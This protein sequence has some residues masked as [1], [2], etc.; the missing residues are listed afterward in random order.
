MQQIKESIIN[1]H[2]QMPKCVLKRFENDNNSFFYYIVEKDLIGKNGHAKSI[3]TELGYY[4]KNTEEFLN[5]NVETPF[6]DLLY[7]IDKIDFDSPALT[8]EKQSEIDKTVKRFIYSLMVRSPQMIK[9]I[10][11]NSVFYQFLSPQEQHDYAAEMGLSHA[12]EID[13]FKDYLVTFAVNKSSIPYVLPMNGV[14]CIII[15]GMETMFL[16]ISPELSIVLMS[17]EGESKII[18]NNMISML[19]IKDS[20]YTM[21]LNK[22]AFLTQKEVGKGYIVSSKRTALE[23]MRL[24]I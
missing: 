1:S 9:E 24:V 5:N 11:K 7:K 6:S 10:K 22:Y 14:Y 12:E 4:S 23:K 19:L 13:P 18:R 15:D 16:P 21:K 3:N 20:K 8:F 2:I 17:K